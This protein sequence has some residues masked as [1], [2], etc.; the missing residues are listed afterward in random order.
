[1]NEKAALRQER[2]AQLRQF[3]DRDVERVRASIRQATAVPNLCYHLR[4]HGAAMAVHTE[5]EYLR[6]LREHLRR[7]DLRVFT[8]LR[9]RGHVPFWELVASDTGTTVVYN[10]KR[11]Q[12][13]SFFQ[14][15]DADGRMRYAETAWIEVIR[16]VDGWEFEES[17][18]WRK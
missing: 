12:I 17:W 10:S 5:D 9:P 14:P 4:K 15:K 16:L 7:E 3:T 6:A 1:M 11:K 8:Y 13:W 18:R 2:L